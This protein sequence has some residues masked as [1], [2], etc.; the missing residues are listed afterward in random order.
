MRE[1]APHLPGHRQAQCGGA[2]RGECRL[3]RPHV[4]VALEAT[5][6]PQQARRAAAAEARRVQVRLRLHPPGHERRDGDRR[7]GRFRSDGLRGHA[8]RR[9]PATAPGLVR[10]LQALTRALRERPAG[11]GPGAHVRRGLRRPRHAD[12]AGR[13]PGRRPAAGGQAREEAAVRRGERAR[14][15]RVAR[16][17]HRR[18]RRAAPLRVLRA[19][20]AG[21]AGGRQTVGP[22]VAETDVPAAASRLHA[23]D[24]RPVEDPGA[25]LR[26]R[27]PE[28]GLRGHLRRPSADLDRRPAEG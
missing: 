6:L 9:V 15:R 3:V 16:G 27:A 28:R 12:A 20:P 17:G 18:L 11:G 21:V 23:R 26:L 13:G 8:G 24:A 14:G 25:Q 10:E 1:L 7:L 5:G 19:P 22:L 2:L 4:N